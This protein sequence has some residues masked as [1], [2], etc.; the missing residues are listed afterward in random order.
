MIYT[1]NDTIRDPFCDLHTQKM[2]LFGTL[3]VIYTHINNDI[4]KDPF[5]YLYIENDIIRD[6]FCDLHA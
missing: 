6:L 4:I 2:K 3:S 1:Q 5:C